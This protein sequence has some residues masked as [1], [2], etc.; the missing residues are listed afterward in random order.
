MLF[1]AK[2]IFARS[3]RDFIFNFN[4]LLSRAVVCK[5]NR[6]QRKFLCEREYLDVQF[7]TLNPSIIFILTEKLRCFSETSRMTGGICKVDKSQIKFIFY[8]TLS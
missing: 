2:N 1:N 8:L 5:R 4:V 6:F 3:Y 7:L